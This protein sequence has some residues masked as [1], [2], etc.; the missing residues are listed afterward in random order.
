MIKTPDFS[1]TNTA[2][3]PQTTETWH[4]LSSEQA[5]EFLQ[6]DADDGL[7]SDEIERRNQ[8]F[9]SNELKETGGRSP[10]TILWEQ[11]TNIM[12]VMLIAV[13]LVSLILDLQQQNF[14]KD[15]IAIF[16]IVILNGIL[17][18]LQESR[19]EQALA[20]LK[21]L[22]SPHV[23]VI[24]DGNTQEVE[25]KELVPGDIML[26]EAGVQIAADG[27]LLSAQNLQIAESTLTGEA[28]AVNKDAGA[29]LTE[30][31]PLGDHAVPAFG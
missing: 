8:Y 2:A 27:R 4:A 17:G 18:Y 13:A 6:S 10:L 15:A 9:G 28:T 12:L 20:A 7:S 14:P 19:A 11:F 16:A 25:A 5:T 22:S 3:M 23:R 29:V 24:R 26:I 21:R 30:D 31:I 1:T